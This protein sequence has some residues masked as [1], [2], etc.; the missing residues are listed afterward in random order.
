[1]GKRE[2][3]K[4]GEMTGGRLVLK[5]HYQVIYGIHGLTT[6]VTLFC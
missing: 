1:M 3:A 5:S 4:G 2:G 6:S